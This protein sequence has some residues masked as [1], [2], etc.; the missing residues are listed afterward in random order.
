MEKKL[1]IGLFLLGLLA[2]GFTSCSDDDPDTPAVENKDDEKEILAVKEEMKT[3]GIVQQLCHVTMLE[4]STFQYEPAMGK[5]L[6]EITPT[7]YYEP[8][9]SLEEAEK[10][11]RRIISPL[12]TDSLGNDNT[13]LREITQGDVHLKFE[14]GSSSKELAKIVVDCPRLR[15]VLTEIVFMPKDQWP[16]N[17]YASPFMYWS[18]WRYKPTGHLYLC[19][20]SAGGGPGVLLTFEGGW[21]E[22]WFKKYDFWQGSFYVWQNT[23]KSADIEAL[24]YS[25]CYEKDNVSKVIEKL[26]EKILAGELKPTR[27]IE[28]LLDL[29]NGRKFTFDTK[30][31]YDYHWYWVAHCYDVTVYRTEVSNAGCQNT[32]SFY[33]HKEVPRKEWP[34]HA[35]YFDPKSYWE[36]EIQKSHIN[37]Y[38]EKKN[39]RK[40][41]S[42]TDE[43]KKNWEMVFRGI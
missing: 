21:I 15:D 40:V 28:V 30:C 16:E 27:T 35:I 9:S 8:V 41:D 26:K 22:D 12:N 34:S 2:F 6:Y 37:I 17:D 20:K 42:W 18:V 39:E 29:Q 11:F 1:M 14:L 32:S 36:W 10:V 19:V 24:G 25:F 38:S 23:A 33:T 43:K 5:A 4:D 3:E 31:T 13:K 7:V